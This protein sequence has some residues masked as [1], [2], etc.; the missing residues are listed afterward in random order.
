ML[1]LP[2]KGPT[3]VCLSDLT[4]SPSQWSFLDLAPVVPNIIHSFICR[5]LL[6]SLSPW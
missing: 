6:V 4:H 1:A 3:Q 5:A 2:G